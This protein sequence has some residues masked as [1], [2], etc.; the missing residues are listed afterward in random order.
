MAPK[1]PLLDSR[2]FEVLLSQLNNSALKHMPPGWKPGKPGA[3]A[4]AGVMLQ[5]TFARLMEIVIERL[6]RVPEKQMLAFLH[7]MNVS[8]LPP[9]PAWAPLVFELKKDAKP[10]LV[11]RRTAVVAKTSG[12]VSPVFETAEDLVVLPAALTCAYTLEP[13]RDRFGDYTGR[14][15]GGLFTPFI[16]ESVMPDAWY[17]IVDKALNIDS[18]SETKLE[19]WLDEESS[20]EVNLNLFL[21]KNKTVWSYSGDGGE[22]GFSPAI[23]PSG[24][25]SSDK[26]VIISVCDADSMGLSPLPADHLGGGCEPPAGGFIK[27]AVKNSREAKVL[28]EK[29]KIVAAAL[30]MEGKK[31]APK[32][33][34]NNTSRLDPEGYVLPF[35]NRPKAG[36]AFYINVGDLPEQEGEIQVTVMLV[37]DIEQKNRCDT[38]SS[39]HQCQL[40][41]FNNNRLCYVG[42]SRKWEQL[43]WSYSSP[44]GWE[45]IKTSGVVSCDSAL[46]DDSDSQAYFNTYSMTFKLE[47]PFQCKVAGEK[48]N[49]LRVVLPANDCGTDA[50]YEHDEKTK[51]WF[52]KPD[53]GKFL[54]PKV[55]SMALSVSF[56]AECRVYR[57]KGHVYTKLD[58]I[59]EGNDLSSAADVG[60][61]HDKTGFYLG[62]DQVYHNMPVSLYV[63]TAPTAHYTGSSN[64][65]SPVWEC[66]TADG[67]RPVYVHDD[68]ADFSRSGAIRF[69]FP[70]EA[71]CV[72]LFDGTE[73][74]WVRLLREGG[75]Q[76][77]GIYLNAVPAEQA[78][79][80]DREA[81]GV[82]N[83]LAGQSFIMRG[84]P[85]LT[86]QRI[87]VREDEAPTAAELA[88][89]SM[90]I[91][92]N[93][94]TLVQE[95]WVL[96]HEQN[97]FWASLPNSR[98]YTLDRDG[99]EVCF[100]DG[101]NGMIPVNGAAI[102]AEYRY[103]GGLYGNLPERSVSKLSA[104]IP[105]VAGVYNPIAATGGADTEDIPGIQSRGPMTLRHRGRGVTVSDI[106]WLVKESAGAAVDRIKCL[107]G[108]GG[109]PFVLML[110]P[111][112]DGLRPLPDGA[113]TTH[114]RN[115]LSRCLP[116][117]LPAGSFGIVGPRY[118][119]INLSVAVVPVDPF[120]SSIVR[121]RV[122]GR[123]STFLHPRQGGQGGSGWEFGRNV[124]LSEV[125]AV[126]ESVEGVEY[127]L[128]DRVSVLPA[129]VQRELT[130]QTNNIRLLTNYPA[131]SL[132]FLYGRNGAVNEQWLLAEPIVSDML[133]RTI[134]VTGLREGDAPTIAGRFPNQDTLIIN[135]IRD[136]DNGGYEVKAF[137]FSED[138]ELLPGMVL[139]CVRTKIKDTVGD[140]I[141]YDGDSI[142]IGF[143][144]F[145]RLKKQEY[146][147]NTS[148]P[149]MV[150][151]TL[152]DGFGY[153]VDFLIN[154]ANTVTDVAYLFQGEL[155]TPGIIDVQ[156][157]EKESW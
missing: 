18:P 38:G 23:Q 9:V 48:G 148:G 1:S 44:D 41:T 84:T 135:D 120:E 35:G 96:W 34:F 36:D 71:V 2:K 141:S 122:A 39:C 5:H 83:G 17:F 57:Q 7:S 105:G 67:W 78:I 11:P 130:L 76:L 102:A 101:M 125:C 86:G 29:V 144:G 127:S 137:R 69:L 80:V 55:R 110:L 33:L 111:A 20:G 123:L 45:P 19:F 3:G 116:A 92:Q 63:D 52:L 156:I 89:T 124:Y 31:Y 128:A 118:I 121:D 54:Y 112:G 103:G 72:K 87:W 98:H 74:Y 58:A 90:E 37:P 108:E 88:E 106:E 28:A 8:P 64:D 82:S 73:R 24:T 66:R 134:R 21:D 142:T 30:S 113:L 94:I 10:T 42:Y 119:T 140:S 62:F 27:C 97:S 138:V 109:Q 147:E 16:G 43:D 49:W 77:K 79:T 26:P 13:S 65:R 115:Y 56:S 95:N 151:L 153:P 129:A 145:K 15:S 133:P 70:T 81:L 139:D 131:G 25:I 59:Q 100:G 68:T 155:C 132:L 75:V 61:E 157:A 149:L 104:K 47:K 107:P 85:V 117:S 32:Q 114:I 136:T 60:A 4:D 46:G 12:G 99:G 146:A 51:T 22:C 152:P 93:P 53:T 126:L 6:N 154:T 91:R 143:E 40:P 50:E 150:R 14:L